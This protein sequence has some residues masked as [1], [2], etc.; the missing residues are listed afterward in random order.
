MRKPRPIVIKLP[1]ERSKLLEKIIINARML[2]FSVVYIS[3]EG[4]ERT[5]N[6][7]SEDCKGINSL[8]PIIAIKRHHS[9]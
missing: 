4:L 8:S 1:K 3:Q 2:E 6:V 7:M 9:G 5:G